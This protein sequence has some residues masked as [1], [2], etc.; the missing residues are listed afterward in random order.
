MLNSNCLPIPTPPSSPGLTAG[1]SY[2]A[3]TLDKPREGARERT[4][5]LNKVY[6]SL[7]G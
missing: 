6:E 7:N 3:R 4:V 5:T 2:V 1:S